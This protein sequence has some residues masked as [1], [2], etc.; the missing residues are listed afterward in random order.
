M[1]LYITNAFDGN[2]P[3]SGEIEG[4][5]STLIGVTGDVW[6]PFSFSSP[7]PVTAGT[8]YALVVYGYD[9]DIE[10]FY[11]IEDNY[12]DG[13]RYPGFPPPGQYYDYGFATYYDTTFP[14]L[15]SSFLAI[16]GIVGIVTGVIVLLNKKTR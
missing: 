6:V 11:D 12:A 4:Q 15:Q 7:V 9:G 8:T 3:T 14:E 1:T 13:V 2:A 5:T 16:L 10:W